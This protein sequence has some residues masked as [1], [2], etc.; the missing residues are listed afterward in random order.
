MITLA[1]RIARGT[2]VALRTLWT[3]W[4]TLGL[5]L[6]VG[7]LLIGMPW[8]MVLTLALAFVSLPV[9]IIVH[10]VGHVWA[11]AALGIKG[12]RLER[13]GLTV[14]VSTP[15]S[16]PSQDAA[17]AAGGPMM[18]AAIGGLV[19]VVELLWPTGMAIAPAVIIGCAS[20]SLLP[21]LGDGREFWGWARS[22]GSAPARIG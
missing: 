15:R 7:E 12:L 14:A 11:A 22:A 19:A 4:F 3:V 2:L 5:A 13:T 10:E 20:L 6:V 9:S 18:S 8:P 16:T 1:S 21:F 17:V